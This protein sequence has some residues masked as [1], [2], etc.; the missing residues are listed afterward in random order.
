MTQQEALDILKTGANV[1]LTG[2]A[3]SGKTYVLREYIRYLQEKGVSVGITASTGIAATHMGG[4]TIHSWAGIG[5]ADDLTHAEIGDLAEQPRLRKR[6]SETQ[7]LIIDEISMLHHSRLDL[8]NKVLTTI[9]GG[10]RFFDNSEEKPFGGIQLVLCGDFFQLPPVS[11]PGEPEALFAYHAKSWRDANLQVCYLH[12]QHRQSDTTYYNILNAIRANNVDE[13]TYSLLRSRH[14]KKPAGK[15]EPTLLHAHNVNVDS[16]NEKEL[17]KISG[18]TYSYQMET[19]GRPALVA[20]LQKSCLAPE[21]LKLKVGARVMFVKNLNE[22]GCFNGTLGVV[23]HCDSYS[24]TVR[25]HDGRRVDVEQE[26]WRIEE[27]GKI[28]AEIKQY[29]LRLAWAI[30]VHKS[31]GMSLDAAIVDLRKSFAPGMGYVAL[32]RVRSLE[33]LCLLGINNTALS[34]HPE[35]LEIDQQFQAHS[36]NCAAHLK[37]QSKKEIE[38]QHE[39]FLARATPKEKEKKKKPVEASTVAQTREL[40]L[41]E[42][43]ISDIAKARSLADSTILDHLEQIKKLEPGFDLR[44]LRK[45]V[46]ADAYEDIAE[47]FEKIGKNEKGFYPLSPVHKELKGKQEYDTIRIVRLTL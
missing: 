5:I 44:Y 18:K 6:F 14:N 7:V 27:D 23:E 8:I 17:S 29:P 37:R 10:N 2:A 31:Q 28:K 12:E 26:T 36:T 35:V 33:G 43:S 32:S 16:E 25:T 46:E 19:K 11:R 1:F 15:T 21:T 30:T 47:A 20:A 45:T 22:I 4:T 9:R 39:D 13:D 3:G 42:L 24:I 38:K 34:V 41:L 40:A